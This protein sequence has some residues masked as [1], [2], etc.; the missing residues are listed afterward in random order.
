MVL[1]F[2]AYTTDWGVHVW[3]IPFDFCYVDGIFKIL[4]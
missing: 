2:N 4:T 1:P 3:A